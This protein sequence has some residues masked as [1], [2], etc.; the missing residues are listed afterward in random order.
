MLKISTTI[1][2]VVSLLLC[3]V[4]SADSWET[5][6]NVKLKASTFWDGTGWFEFQRRDRWNDDGHFYE[7]YQFILGDTTRYKLF[8]YGIGYRHIKEDHLV[9][10]RPHIFLTPQV[11]VL[12]NKVHL[13]VRNKLEYRLRDASPSDGFRYKIQ[14]KVAYTAYT[15]GSV[16][17][18]PYI[19]DELAYDFIEGEIGGNKVDVGVAIKFK[20]KYE[21]TPFYQYEH[22]MATGHKDDSRFGVQG[23]YTF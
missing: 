4:A 8:K 2:F 15:N 11:R 1:I 22:D 23:R 7:H 13:S 3:S 14:P 6:A 20:R 12:D 21:I 5:N 19:A 17:V 16:K 10:H 18:I 9:E